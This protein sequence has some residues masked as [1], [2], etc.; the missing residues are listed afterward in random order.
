VLTA[1]FLLVGA[2]A[3]AQPAPSPLRA[4][5]ISVSGGLVAAGGYAVGDRVAELRRGSGTE[6]L[7]LF[8]A[9]SAF[10][11]ATGVD[12]RVGYAVTSWLALEA[13]GSVSRPQ[14]T[15]SVTGDTEALAPVDVTERVSTYTVGGSG[16][17]YLPYRFGARGRPYVSGGGEYLRQLH[18]DRLLAETGHLIFAGGG[19]RYWLRGMPGSRRAVG[20]RGDASLVFRSGGVELDGQSRR[21]PR[22]SAL[23][24]FA[25]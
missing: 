12:V 6:G 9:E 2:S 15:V 16:V 22:L 7:P 8:R 17:V 4:G 23:A 3:V 25:F 11:A 10:D 21:Y 19:V 14:L 24:F 18:D 13:S 20:V 1:A 5:E